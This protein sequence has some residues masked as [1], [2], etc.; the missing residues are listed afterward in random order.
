MGRYATEV[1]CP[2]DLQLPGSPL[3]SL[4]KRLKDAGSACKVKSI[5]LQELL[6]CSKT[7]NDVFSENGRERVGS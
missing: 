4:D 5:A 1:V 2:E 7:T 3:Q 6:S